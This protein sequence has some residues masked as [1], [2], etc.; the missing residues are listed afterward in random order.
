MKKVLL[1]VLALPLAMLVACVV[2]MIITMVLL[3]RCCLTMLL[4]VTFRHT[5]RVRL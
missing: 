2:M 4:Q 1:A 5:I 3:R